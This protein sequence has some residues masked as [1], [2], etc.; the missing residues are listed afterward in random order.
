MTSE[1]ILKLLPASRALAVA[2]LVGVRASSLA[3]ALAGASQGLEPRRV[4]EVLS[5]EELRMLCNH[6][7]VV[8]GP[9]C[10]RGHVIDILAGRPASCEVAYLPWFGK[11]GDS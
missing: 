4:L 5:E 11:R 1:R 9:A 6:V 2:A 8:P 3:Q 10:S 7:G